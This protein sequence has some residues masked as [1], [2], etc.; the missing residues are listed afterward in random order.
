MASA[1]PIPWPDTPE[2][3]A[4][5]ILGSD[6][7][8]EDDEDEDNSSAAEMPG[9]FFDHRAVFPHLDHLLRAS[10]AI[11]AEAEEMER[12]MRFTPWPEANLYSRRDQTGD[13]K[14]VPLLYTFPARDASKMKWVRANCERCPVTTGFLKRIP[15]VR[16][17][18]FSRMGP[19]TRLSSH[20]G[21]A[22][23]ANHVLR[24]HLPLRVPTDR[25]DAC[26]V[27]VEGHVTHHRV[28]DLVV[29]DDSRLH[30]AFNLSP[31]QDRIVLIFDLLRPEN[32]PLGRAQ[33][34]HTQALDQFIVDFQQ[35]MELVV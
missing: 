23:L 34:G 12:A 31:T 2:S 22:D 20:R 25:P 18:L 6:A 26:G 10:E 32:V 27:W 33:G 16:T 7:E 4:R 1:S 15:G 28:G 24:C 17:A 13:W 19:R 9:P 11:L 8:R 30:K 29:F 21:W 3:T 14:V 5:W 35:A